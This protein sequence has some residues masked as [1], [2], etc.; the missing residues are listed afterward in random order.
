[1]NSQF[2]DVVV[3]K[4]SLGRR[5]NDEDNFWSCVFRLRLDWAVAMIRYRVESDR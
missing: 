2:G 5:I 4:E 3:K 1:M